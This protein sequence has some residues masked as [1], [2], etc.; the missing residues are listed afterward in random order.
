MK[1]IGIIGT[2]C[3]G[4]TT[5]AYGLLHALKA[6]G[7]H[8]DGLVQTDCMIPFD[9]ELLDT[10]PMAQW[11]I[12]TNQIRLEANMSLQK[13]IDVMVCDRT[14]FDLYVYF[15]VALRG[16]LV[17]KQMVDA[18]M[19]TYDKVY[20]LNPVTFQ[21]SDVRCDE[22]FRDRIHKHLLLHVNNFN[23]KT[24]DYLIDRNKIIKEPAENIHPV[25]RNAIVVDTVAGVS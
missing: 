20:F 6:A 7:I 25:W 4:K 23:E 2:A 16:S 22:A 1:K 15:Q 3:S 10:H 12:I 11:S 17:L 13:G 14:P 18:W 5:L 21:A 8:A 9:R 24:E 19:A